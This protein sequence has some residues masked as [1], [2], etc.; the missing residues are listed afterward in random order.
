MASHPLRSARR[1]PLA[2]L[3][4]GPPPLGNRQRIPPGVAGGGAWR[5][6][7]RRA[8]C[9]ARCAVR[10]CGRCGDGHVAFNTGLCPPI[11]PSRRISRRD[12]TRRPG[13]REQRDSG[14]PAS[15]HPARSEPRAG[16]R[17]R[18]ARHRP[19][20]RLRAFSC[21]RRPR[22]AHCLAAQRARHAHR[23]IRPRRDSREDGRCAGHTVLRVIGPGAQP[24]RPRT[25]GG[26]RAHRHRASQAPSRTGEPGGPVTGPLRRWRVRADPSGLEFLPTAART[27]SSPRTAR[28]PGTWPPSRSRPIS[29]GCCAL[30][31]S[32]L[33]CV[34]SLTFGM[35]VLAEQH[36]W[37]HL[38]DVPNADVVLVPWPDGS[39]H[40]LLRRRAAARALHERRARGR[41]DKAAHGVL[42]PDGQLPAGPR[43]RGAS[44]RWLRRSYGPVPMTR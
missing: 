8:R 21:R 36:H 32:V 2:S 33:A 7:K 28:C 16:I 43:A 23:H 1:A 6:R 20:R 11:P 25:P 17:Q 26:R 5:D 30:A 27:A 22:P 31:G 44:A 4:R 41:L 37:P 29:P 15:A 19:R 9:P 42:A 40:P 10:L 39:H 35:A 12:G 18:R 24:R 3:A 14:C 13:E 38:I 34:D